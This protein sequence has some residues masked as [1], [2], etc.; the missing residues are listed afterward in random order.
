MIDHYSMWD[1]RA[2]NRNI[3]LPEVSGK[4]CGGVVIEGEIESLVPLPHS[5]T[6]C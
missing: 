3:L 5:L 2:D 1:W 4:V 6:G